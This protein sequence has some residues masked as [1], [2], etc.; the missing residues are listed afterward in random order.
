MSISNENS[1]KTTIATI[2]Y[3]IQNII[4]THQ[5]DLIK[6]YLVVYFDMWYDYGGYKTH[7]TRAEYAS[8]WYNELKERINNTDASELIK[9]VE[10]IL[11]NE[12]LMKNFRASCEKFAQDTLFLTDI[13]S[14]D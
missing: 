4:K 7:A 12:L 2:R 8:R 6:P 11:D 10:I 1:F 3:R 9:L 5:N 14:T 13:I